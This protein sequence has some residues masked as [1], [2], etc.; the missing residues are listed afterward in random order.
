MY[1]YFRQSWMI[2]CYLVKQ[3]VTDDCSKTAA[4]LAYS[5]LLAI[6]PLMLVSLSIASK[7]PTFSHVV[8]GLQQFVLTNFV[9]GA[10]GSIVHYLDDFMSQVTHLSWTNIVAFTV[11]GLLLLYN[12]V[13]AFNSIWHVQM[14]WHW[15]FT[16]RFLFYFTILLLAPLMLAVLLLI[17]S[18]VTSLSLFSSN[19]F[20]DMI[21]HPLVILSPYL[22]AFVTFS[23]FNWVLPT[24]QV[25]LRYALVSGFVSMIFFELIKYFFTWYISVFP[26]YKIIYGA[27][28]TIPIFFI[29]IYLSWVV[30]LIGAIFCKGLHLYFKALP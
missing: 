22:A 1:H 5:T 28:A 24:C 12:M 4:S 30:I 7:V 17:V 3:Y 9:T 2:S 6:V 11:T 13:M 10:A 23:F 25:K 15:H 29:W 26:T 21:T 18:Y 8:N 20:H 14:T 19:Y 16:L 27:L